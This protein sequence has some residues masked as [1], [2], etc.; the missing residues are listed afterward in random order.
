MDETYAWKGK[1]TGLLFNK[2]VILGKLQ[3]DISEFY[4]VKSPTSTVLKL[5]EVNNR[6]M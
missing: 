2:D 1:K 3:G 4:L 5:L 6:V